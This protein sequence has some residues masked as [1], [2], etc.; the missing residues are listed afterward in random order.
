MGRCV[1]ETEFE[2]TL[3]A[4]LIVILELVPV[5]RRQS[6]WIDDRCVDVTFSYGK[7]VVVPDATVVLVKPERV[8]PDE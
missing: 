4:D 5:P 1:A 8:A 3:H 7:N 6:P 2:R